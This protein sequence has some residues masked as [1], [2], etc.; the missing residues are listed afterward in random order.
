MLELFKNLLFPTQY[1]PHGHCYLWQTPL[2]GLYVIS[3]ALI[4]I[5]Y[6]SIPAMLI[7]FVRKREN[8]PFSNVFQMFGAF[9]I[10]CGTGHLLDIWTL[11]FPA[12]WVAGVE[13]ALTALVSCY[14]ALRLLELLPQFLAMKTPDQ[15]GAINRELE[16][17]I[18]ERQRTEE[19]LQTI[20]AGT[21]TVTGDAFFPALAQNLA[22][23]LGVA[24]V[25]VCETVD[26]RVPTLRTLALWVSDRLVD[27]IEYELTGTPCKVA[28]QSRSLC[29]YSEHLQ[30]QFPDSPMLKQLKAE[31][32]VGVPLLD[33]NQQPIGHLCVLDVKPFRPDERT[34][35][36][37]SVFAAR[38]ATEL[39]R[40]WAED[41]KRRAYE[42][43]EVRV[44]A[45]TSEWVTTNLA[46]ESEI[47]ERIGVETAL[48][49]SQEQFS[50]AF[51]SN[52]IACS[53]STLNEGRFLDV[54][55]SFVKLFGYRREDIIGRTSAELGIWVNPADRDRLIQHLQQHPSLQQDAPFY[56][57]SGEVREGMSSFERIELQGEACLL[58]MIYDIT[59]RKQAEA[60]QLQQM[61]L[62]ALR[63]DIGAA[64]TEGESVQEMLQQCAIALHEHLDAAFARIWTLDETEQLLIL[65]ASAGLY[66]HLDG[67]HSRIP[68]GQFKIGW[69]AEHHQ[70][71]LTNEITTDPR[72]VDQEW[73]KHE[74]II[75]FAGYPLTIKNRLL[76]VMAIF[77]RRRLTERTLKEMESI[78]S[79]IAVGIDRKLS[80]EALRQTA[81]RERA[82]ARMLQRMHASLELETIFRTTTEELRH[83]VQCD[84]VLIYQFN[85]DW[86][87]QVVSESV[88]DPWEAIL[89][90]KGDRS[91]LNQVTVDR[92]DCI[93]R[94][95][96]GTEVV[97]RDTYLQERQGG[98][99]HD[100]DYCCVRDVQQERFDPCYLELMEALQARAYIIVPIFCGSQLWGL[101]A[102]Y[103]NGEP[104]HWQSAEI[105]MVLQ[106]GT[107]LGV[108]VQQ[109][110]LFA[111]IQEQA[112]ELRYAKD[113][114]DAANRAKSEFLANMSHE[115][116]TPLNA[117]LGFTQ[118]MQRDATLSSEH[119]RSVKIV[120]QSGEHLLGLIND[121]LEMSKIEAG[122]VTLHEAECDFYQLLHSLEDMLRL[123]AYSKGLNLL[124]TYDADIPHYIKIDKNKLRQV[125]INLV[126]NAIKFTEQGSV[127]L[128]VSRVRYPSP[129]SAK[130]GTLL[131][132][133][134]D[135]G[136][137]IGVEELGDLFQA[138]KQTR[139][140]RQSQEGTGLGLRISQQFVQLMGGNITVRSELNRGSC[141]AFSIPT[142]FVDAPPERPEFSALAGHTVRLA[143]NVTR[144]RILIAEDNPNNRLL[145]R[146][147]LIE[148]GF[149][150]QEAEN[151]QRAIALWQQWQPDLIFMDM[152]MPVLNG[153]E[154]TQQIRA[155]E[156]SRLAAGESHA[157]SG[158]TPP[159]T[160]II[161]LTASAFTEQ[162]QESLAAGCDDFVSKPF[163]HAALLNTLSH[164]LG[165]QYVHDRLESEASSSSFTPLPGDNLNTEDLAI[166]PPDWLHQLHQSATKG[167][168]ETCFELIRQVPSDHPSLI[169][170]LTTWV[171]AYQFDQLITFIQPCIE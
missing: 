73:A 156:R 79:A 92:N 96:N 95:F 63:A 56:I 77:A 61:R 117:I 3:D 71:H 29:T 11:W 97:I 106:I 74:G 119:Q 23:A 2:V 142:T 167:D 21:S 46:L 7:Y 26:A 88:G 72:I 107:Q 69:I 144:H 152:H 136:S 84:R 82:A 145:L 58:S 100:N 4:A 169:K 41:A 34:Q 137:G 62:A 150:V 30:Q 160:K 125:L 114:A 171:E 170:A 133:V 126:G 17:Q 36:L 140:G 43:L 141:F 32:Y 90:G 165:I 128:R 39:Q 8:I 81:E 20:V 147:L 148:L 159:R 31:S 139:T 51:H 151:G 44:E 50:K 85:P 103:Q 154:A 89:R 122:Q 161:A 54:N 47:R 111:Q 67:A 93:M 14:T 101:L 130:Q 99:Y 68:V 118:L 45:R 49:H 115:L 86:S 120:N 48:R 146:Q 52:P 9:I 16:E 59:E 163:Q 124:F 131:F 166:M 168:D 113:V 121:V 108:A 155:E 66:S 102:T 65:Q 78:A 116:R 94:R 162:R 109:A 57:R 60:E 12:Y 37:F 19:T 112:K 70:P 157:P 135:T 6:F 132:E 91:V 64:L 24:Y 13:R 1:V 28:L 158:E 35:A 53:I 143:P 134:E 40:K 98:L 104:R 42:E 25:L 80:E 27:N 123:K 15:L 10:L 83:L 87:G 153:Y 129:P 33:A 5:A 38:A 18:A 164:H 22:E 75:A 110:E 105:Q 55:T 127:T 138:F 76:G 149:E